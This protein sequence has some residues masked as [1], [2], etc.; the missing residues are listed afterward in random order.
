MSGM[1]DRAEGWISLLHHESVVGF[2][3]Y[4]GRK[5]W[6]A[7]LDQYYCVLYPWDL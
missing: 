3:W 7:W 4:R 1:Q 2:G 6:R 5:G